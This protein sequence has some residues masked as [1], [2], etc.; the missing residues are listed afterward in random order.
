MGANLPPGPR[1]I[2]AAAARAV[3]P[4]AVRRA[5]DALRPGLLADGGNAELIAVEEDGTVRVELQ[6]A[7]AACPAR[8]QTLRRVLEPFLRRKV[9]GVTSVLAS[10]ARELRS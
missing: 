9:A 2:N 10:L 3:D 5:L 7:C 8:E 4:R 1:L 6:G